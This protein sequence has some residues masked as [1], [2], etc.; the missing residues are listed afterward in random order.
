MCS[1]D[2]KI[3]A[4]FDVANST[5]DVRLW[6]SDSLGIEATAGILVNSGFNMDMGFGILFPL[7]EDDISFYLAPKLG[8]GFGYSADETDVYKDEDSR[9]SISAGAVL[10]TEVF[11][12]SISKNLSIGAGVGLG[13]NINIHN[14]KYTLKATNSITE[15]STTSFGLGIVDGWVYPLTIRYYF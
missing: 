8:I 1:S 2:L 6:A 11:L 9:I 7:S 13:I 4:G 5:V 14:A 3:S 15:G 12:K 10:K